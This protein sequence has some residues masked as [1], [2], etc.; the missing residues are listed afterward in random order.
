MMWLGQV[1]L[2]AAV[3]VFE[4]SA[5][6][7]KRSLF[8]GTRICRPPSPTQN[9]VFL[10]ADSP[11]SIRVSGSSC[12]G[13]EFSASQNVEDFREDPAFPQL[14]NDRNP[15]EEL[16][17]CARSI[18]DTYDSWESRPRSSNQRWSSRSARDRDATDDE[19]E[20]VYED[21]AFPSLPK[22]RYLL[23][24]TTSD[25]EDI[26]KSK[27][28]HLS[29]ANYSPSTMKQVG[30]ESK[31]LPYRKPASQDQYE[32]DSSVFQT[33]TPPIQIPAFDKNCPHCNKMASS[34]KTM[35]KQPTDSKYF[36]QLLQTNPTFLRKFFENRQIRPRRFSGYDRKANTDAIISADNVDPVGS[37]LR[38]KTSPVVIPRS[39]QS[40]RNVIG[41]QN[42]PNV[43][44]GPSKPLPLELF[45]KHILAEIQSQVPQSKKPAK[46]IRSNFQGN[47]QNP[48]LPQTQRLPMNQNGGQTVPSQP[49]ET[50]ARLNLQSNGQSNF[51]ANPPKKSNLPSDPKGFKVPAT[52]SNPALPTISS[53]NRMSHPNMKTSESSRFPSMPSSENQMHRIPQETRIPSSPQVKINPSSLDSL[54]KSGQA[55]PTAKEAPNF[56]EISRN[57]DFSAKSP[58]LPVTESA[59][60]AELKSTG[61]DP[62]PKKPARPSTQTP[63][64]PPALANTGSIQGE[65]PPNSAKF[66]EKPIVKIVNF[67]R[68]ENPDI[69]PPSK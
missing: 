47:P 38:S 6:R 1:Y 40:P 56:R 45:P 28:P 7:S 60:P 27:D 53:Q 68:Q 23:I 14:F 11:R 4:A 20:E 9:S 36:Q 24:P 16:S 63:E 58:T 69:T 12:P 49:I 51:P 65:A 64:T 13:E 18:K 29:T 5:V 34:Q 35:F 22:G 19:D 52:A 41:A 42:K 31:E 44:Q 57:L 46:N 10:S 26:L 21:K 62:V 25:L 59:P 39:H 37:R 61:P 2:L 54:S 32:M 48:Q 17:R 15:V 43:P 55:A 30:R 3:C 8:G 66:Q 33:E 50:Y 67:S